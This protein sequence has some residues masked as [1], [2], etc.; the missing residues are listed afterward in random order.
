MDGQRSNV[1]TDP[2]LKTFLVSGMPSMSKNRAPAARVQSQNWAALLLSF[3]VIAI[4]VLTAMFDF[5]GLVF[6][7]LISKTSIWDGSLAKDRTG[8]IVVRTSPDHCQQFE[9]DNDSGLIRRDTRPCKVEASE[10][11]S[12]PIGTIRRLDAISKSFLE[13]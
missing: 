3:I 2:S 9:F 10:G 6:A 5:P 4:I 1:A 13:R 8:T 7:H 12:A 11:G